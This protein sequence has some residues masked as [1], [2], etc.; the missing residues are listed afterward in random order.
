MD[1]AVGQKTW[2]QAYDSIMLS[3]IFPSAVFGFNGFLLLRSGANLVLWTVNH[4]LWLDT[5]CKGKLVVG[6]RAKQQG[7]LSF[8]TQKKKHWSSKTVWKLSS[9]PLLLKN[10]AHK[11]FLFS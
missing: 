9:H 5:S 11:I 3:L 10:V 1:R 2:V 4:N 6:T 8:R 7:G